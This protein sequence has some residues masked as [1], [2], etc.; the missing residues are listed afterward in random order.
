MALQE[1]KEILEKR[2]DNLSAIDGAGSILYNMAGTPFSIEKM[3]E[4]KSYHQKHSELQPEDPEP[5]YW[6]GVIDW[7]LAFRGNREMREGVQQ[8]RQ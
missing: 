3:E 7:S 5:Y 2:P 8:D 6:V 1:F 4:S